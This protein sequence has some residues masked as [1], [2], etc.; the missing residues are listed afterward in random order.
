MHDRVRQRLVEQVAKRWHLLRRLDSVM[1]YGAGRSGGNGEAALDVFSGC[2]SE[3]LFPHSG[4]ACL[5][6]LF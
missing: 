4:D 6:V 5:E 3:E 1:V 2:S